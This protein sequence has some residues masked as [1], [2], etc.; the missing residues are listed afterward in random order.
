M[1]TVWQASSVER[2]EMAGP[3][4]AMTNDTSDERA[5]NSS[6]EEDVES[7]PV[8]PE[9]PA[10]VAPA[11]SA[12][13]DST[14]SSGSPTEPDI[15]ALLATADPKQMAPAIGAMLKGA[16]ANIPAISS[17]CVLAIFDEQTSIGSYELNRI[18]RG[19][20]N[21]NPNRDKD[22]LLLLLSNGG[23]IEPA[24]QISKLCKAFAK[25]KF[26]VAV[27]RFAKS[28]ATLIALGAD[29]IH[30]GVLGH[31]GPIDPQVGGLP[32]LAVARA[33]DA[34]AIL[35]EKHPGSSEMLGLYL[36]EK[37][38][39]QQIGYYERVADSAVQ[40]GQRLLQRKDAAVLAAEPAAIAHKLVHEYKDHGF[41]IDSDEAR[42][43]LGSGWVKQGTPEA[44]FA[45]NVYT[46]LDFS[47][48]LMSIGRRNRDKKIALIGSLDPQ[49]LE[50][51]IMIL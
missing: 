39:V 44:E 7:T 21:R 42:E 14:A 16:Q 18:Y 31:L 3:K 5:T 38:A 15:H 48:L 30:M 10:G 26:V 12:G 19:L 25:E 34:L 46:A 2:L 28:A 36:K 17:Y 43:I 6:A 51:S 20:S 27:P 29:E 35:A 22:V 4:L 32:A 33:L 50:H 49:D 24:Y 13:Q 41:V 8:S 47:T 45:D 9:A 23:S 37:L 1:E 40:Y 11:D